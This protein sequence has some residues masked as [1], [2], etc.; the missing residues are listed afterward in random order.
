MADT[1][2]EWTDKT[3]N[4]TTGCDT[5]SDGCDNCYARPLAKRLK[6]MELGRVAKGGLQ[7]ADAKYQTDGDPATSGP[8]FG[9]AEHATALDAPLHWTK[10]AKVFVNSMSDLFHQDATPEFISRVFAVMALTPQHTYQVLTKRAGKMRSLLNQNWF[11]PWVY[12]AMAERTG[13]C[14]I[15]VRWPLPNVWLGTSVEDQKQADLRVPALLDT[16][17]AVRFLSCEPLLG[18]VDLSRWTDAH[19]PWNYTEYGCECSCGAAIVDAQD[20]CS[21]ARIAWVIVGGESGP[22][23]RSMDLAWVEAL[24]TGC[25]AFGV[26][27]HVKQ[28]GSVWGL[29]NDG[30]SKGGDWSRW[31]ERL[32]VRQFPEVSGV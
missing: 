12:A 10:P 31:P 16:P 15:N 27:V 8:G 3:W 30:G 14:V 19:F 9:F 26:P 13:S 1:K 22:G 24:V 18:P 23:A 4:P 17:A 5:V 21:G 11:E 2:I 25:S 28:L 6:A 32:R 7:L 29:A 20:R